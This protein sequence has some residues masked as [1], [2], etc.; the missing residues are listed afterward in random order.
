MATHE[1]WWVDLSRDVV[2]WSVGVW[3]ADLIAAGLLDAHEI[4]LASSLASIV[5]GALCGALW[6]FWDELQAADQLSDL[7]DS[8]SKPPSDG[9]C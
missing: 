6:W 9:E 3:I 2:W 8:D 1:P 5:A 4:T 7:S